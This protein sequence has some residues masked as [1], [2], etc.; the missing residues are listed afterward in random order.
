MDGTGEDDEKT[1]LNPNSDTPRWEITTV[2]HILAFFR[3]FETSL[4]L[5]MFCLVSC[6]F[7]IS[8][9]LTANSSFHQKFS[10]ILTHHIKVENSTFLLQPT[11]VSDSSHNCTTSPLY[12]ASNIQILNCSFSPTHEFILHNQNKLQAKFTRIK[13]VISYLNKPT[14]IIPHLRPPPPPLF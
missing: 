1:P 9:K 4:H 3:M 8:L 14:T 11:V 6:L 5:V 2:L 12:T 13:Q 10:A 7:Y